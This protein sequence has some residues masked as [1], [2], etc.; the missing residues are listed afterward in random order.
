MSKT[1][2][3]L[4]AWEHELDDFAGNKPGRLVAREAHGRGPPTYA[5]MR[6]LLE[7]TYPGRRI[8]TP[9]E[10]APG[11]KIVV[12]YVSPSPDGVGRIGGQG[13]MFNWAVL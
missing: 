5:R 6:A 7:R 10:R 4:V 11:A 8:F 12:V 3:W 9:L 1:T 13:C 2:A